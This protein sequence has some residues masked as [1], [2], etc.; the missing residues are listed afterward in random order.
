[1]VSFIKKNISLS[2]L[3]LLIIS[4]SD[5]QQEVNPLEIPQFVLKTYAD[6][7]PTMEVVKWYQKDA[8]YWAKVERDGIKGTVKITGGG[9]WIATEWEMDV[10]DMPS[11]IKDHLK[12]QYPKFSVSRMILETRMQPNYVIFL[13]NKKEK[14]TKTVFYT[15]TGDFI[16]ELDVEYE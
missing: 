10:K 3:F 2:L 16:R 6:M 7:Y 8:N 15:T 9:S 1:M 5:A 11:K 14:T 4:F 13:F 12:L